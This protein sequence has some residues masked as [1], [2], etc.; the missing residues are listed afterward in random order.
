[1]VKVRVRV[2]VWIRVRIGIV[3]GVSVELLSIRPCLEF[4]SATESGWPIR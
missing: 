3:F 1:M 2:G 4:E